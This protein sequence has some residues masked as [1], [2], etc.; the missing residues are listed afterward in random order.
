M[1]LNIRFQRHKQGRRT[2]RNLDQKLHCLFQQRETQSCPRHQW[3]QRN[4]EV[5]D[6]VTI[7]GLLSYILSIRVSS[8]VASH[9]FET[10][11]INPRT[12]LIKLR[13]YQRRVLK[14]NCSR[15]RHDQGSSQAQI[16]VVMSCPAFCY[17]ARQIKAVEYGH[18]KNPSFQELGG[19]IPG[20][21]FGKIFGQR[22]T[23]LSRHFLRRTLAINLQP[24]CADPTKKVIAKIEI[25]TGNYFN[26]H[27]ARAKHKMFQ[28]KNAKLIF[29]TQIFFSL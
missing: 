9:L 20:Q 11:A 2:F 10:G 16:Y 1:V 3:A 24:F 7:R 18:F 13:R 4:I 12:P 25:F 5:T 6:R 29:S 19:P 15:V 27:L 14:K 28:K 26:H 21:C 22:N 8:K 23:Y 17:Q